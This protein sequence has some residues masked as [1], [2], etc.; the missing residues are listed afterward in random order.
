VVD[1]SVAAFTVIITEWLLAKQLLGFESTTQ[2]A[3][4]AGIVPPGEA[5]AWLHDLE[6][7]ARGVSGR[8]P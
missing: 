3:V 6:E 2:E 8:K 1:V 7:R 5:T 4:S